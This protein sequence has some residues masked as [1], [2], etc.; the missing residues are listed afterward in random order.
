MDRSRGKYGWNYGTFDL[1]LERS[2]LPRSGLRNAESWDSIVL[3]MNVDK[4]P[5]DNKVKR[6]E[7]DSPLSLP[8]LP[9]PPVKLGQVL[10]SKQSDPAIKR[11]KTGAKEDTRRPIPYIG[12]MLFLISVILDGIERFSHLF[13]FLLSF[14]L[15]TFFPVVITIY[16]N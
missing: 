14:S 5:I 10:T 3:S 4:T 11:C 2:P 12:S 1:E 6:V 13:L 9:R 7:C 8:L 15:K 16:G